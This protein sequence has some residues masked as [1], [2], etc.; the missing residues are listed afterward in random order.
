MVL[1]A[2]EIFRPSLCRQGAEGPRVRVKKNEN[3]RDTD[4]TLHRDIFEKYEIIL[5]FFAGFSDTHLIRGY[6]EEIENLDEIMMQAEELAVK[7]SESSPQQ[8]VDD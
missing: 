7:I 1:M 4:K 8:M 6:G 3:R 5:Q 2:C